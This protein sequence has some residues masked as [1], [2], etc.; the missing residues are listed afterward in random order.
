VTSPL[1]TDLKNRQR[2]LQQL[3]QMPLHSQSIHKQ[4]STRNAPA[5]STSTC[6]DHASLIETQRGVDAHLN[7][8]K[9]ITVGSAM[10]QQNCDIVCQ[11][12]YSEQRDQTY[13]NALSQ[14]AVPDL[15]KVFNSAAS[16]DSVDK[17]RERIDSTESLAETAATFQ[18][19][20]D[21][22]ILP[23]MPA[24]PAAKSYQAHV[25]IN[26]TN[27]TARVHSILGAVNMHD[28][29][30]RRSDEVDERSRLLHSAGP[31]KVELL[32]TTAPHSPMHH[33]PP[34][35]PIKFPERFQHS[36]KARGI[37]HQLQ[38]AHESSPLDN[39]VVKPLSYSMENSYVGKVPLDSGLPRFL[40]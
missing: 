11:F 31:V 29:L 25:G 37:S 23:Q 17:V 21:V 39:A 33:Q 9:P 28:K 10:Q 4:P 26:G 1:I 38:I 6:T 36:F 30:C 3:R 2:S 15:V 35:T 7:I 12:H 22:L 27:V 32:S 16:K 20:P 34:N 8:L 5:S 14:L 13:D 40:V 24:P 19:T 18:L